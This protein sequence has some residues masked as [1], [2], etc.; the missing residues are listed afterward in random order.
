MHEKKLAA[1]DRETCTDRVRQD[2]RRQGIGEGEG[3]RE[4]EREI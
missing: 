2:R 3:E 4:R 1:Y